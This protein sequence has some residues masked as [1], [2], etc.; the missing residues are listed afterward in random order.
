MS[1][2]PSINN[3]EIEEHFTENSESEDS[4]YDDED[5]LTRIIPPESEYHHIN[6]HDLMRLIL[7]VIRSWGYK[8]MLKITAHIRYTRFLRLRKC[9]RY[10][11]QLIG[12]HRGYGE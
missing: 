2:N 10:E 12:C 8:T 7:F 11:S 1:R 6:K 3:E 5:E 9:I 4:N